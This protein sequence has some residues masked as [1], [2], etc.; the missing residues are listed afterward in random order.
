LHQT[1][2]NGQ[3]FAYKIFLGKQMGNFWRARGGAKTFSKTTN[4]FAKK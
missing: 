1:I 2:R 4:A 3:F